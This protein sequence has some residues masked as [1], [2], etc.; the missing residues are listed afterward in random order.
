MPLQ[1][2]VSEQGSDNPSTTTALVETGRRLVDNGGAEA[3]ILACGGMADVAAALQAEVGVPVCEGVSFGSML[4]YALWRCGLAT[5]KVGAYGWPEPTPYVA[6]P[7]H[8]RD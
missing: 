8:A 5:S 6:M 1:I 7:A 4:A 2:P 3:L